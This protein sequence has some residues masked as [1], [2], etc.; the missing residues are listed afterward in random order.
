MW[1]CTDSSTAAPPSTASGRI[2]R[3][4]HTAWAHRFPSCC[5]RRRGGRAGACG[6]GAAGP[7]PPLPRCRAPPRSPRGTGRR[8]PSAPRAPGAWAAA[9]PALPTAG[10]A[11]RTARPTPRAAPRCG[12]RPAPRAG[13]RATSARWRRRRLTVVYAV[14]AVIRYSQ[15][16]NC[17]SPRNPE[18]LPGP[19]VGLLHHVACVLLVGRETDRERVRVDVGPADQLVERRAI[20]VACGGDQ[21]VELVRLPRQFVRGHL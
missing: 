20:T 12:S 9:P 14:F 7:S 10:P 4:R 2:G 13:R 8:R 1:R 17:A 6:P 15:V 18:A 19:E 11:Q 3:R 5:R 16:L 21:P